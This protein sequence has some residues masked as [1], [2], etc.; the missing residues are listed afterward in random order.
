MPG[1]HTIFFE[2]HAVEQDKTDTTAFEGVVAPRHVPVFA[3]PGDGVVTNFSSE[4]GGHITDVWRFAVVVAELVDARQTAFPAQPGHTRGRLGMVSIDNIAAEEDEIDVSIADVIEQ[5]RESAA[6]MFERRI[7]PGNAMAV[8]GR[9]EIGRVRRQMKIC[10]L[11]E[12]DRLGN[13][14]IREM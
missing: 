10:H 7:P 14:R 8:F 4:W 5:S 13:P 2:V 9:P 6:G 12:G 11:R 3:K 1:I